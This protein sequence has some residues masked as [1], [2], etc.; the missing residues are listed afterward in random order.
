MK[1]KYFHISLYII[2]PF[3]FSGIACF[4]AII[5]YRLTLDAIT[6]STGF[7][8]SILIWLIVI[9]IG[10]YF[11]GLVLV[12]LILRPIEEFMRKTEELPVLANKPLNTDATDSGDEL[13]HFEDF[14]E[15]VTD[16]LSKVEA[17]ELFPQIIGQSNAILGILSRIKKVSP[18]DTT[19][20]IFG[21]SGTGK[22]LVATSIYEHSLRKGRPLIK[23]NC[24]AIPEGLMESELFGHE[25][26]AFTGAVS[27]IRGKFEIADRGTIFLDEIG[28]MPLTIQA[29]VLRVIQE[30]EFERVGSSKTIKVDIRFIAATNMNLEKMVEEGK[31][32]EDL[33]FRLNVYSI[34]VPP[35]RNRTDDIPFLA[36]YFLK[37]HPDSN[38]I[39]P[40]AMEALSNY[41]WPGNVRELQNTIEQASIISNND[42]DIRSLP[43]KI[44]NAAGNYIKNLSNGN[45]LKSIDEQ[46]SELER[47]IILDALI[48][49]SGVQV[50]AAEL[51]GINQR[52]LW[53]RIKKFNI[54]VK[55]MKKHDLQ[56]M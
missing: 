27:K 3:I 38:K 51:L 15:Q 33:Y 1:K 41:S 25:K 48:K 32:R 43:T 11:C 22:E 20:L 47:R 6:K 28:D 49:S 45:E 14:F 36:D 40:E 24:A 8:W 53:H 10:S 29:K 44:R 4:S 54:D 2:I 12:R 30:K 52:S 56:K 50:K 19:V 16:L 46:L 5:S 17:R 26:G 34:K 7:F 55:E 21:E 37:L 18:T 35:L 42:I 23:I 9:V 39:T 31:F 13:K